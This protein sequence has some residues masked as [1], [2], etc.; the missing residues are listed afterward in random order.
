I[1]VCEQYPANNGQSCETG[2][3]CKS[4]GECQA[5]ECVEEDLDCSDFDSDCTVGVCDLDTGECVLEVTNESMPCADADGCAIAPFCSA[6]V[7]ADPDGGALFYE[8]FANNDAG[9]TLD[10]N[11]QIGPTSANCGD[12]ATD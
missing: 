3:I 10:T 7:C 1:G 9:W 4:N 12:P 5:G 8:P 6:G 11:W 2:E